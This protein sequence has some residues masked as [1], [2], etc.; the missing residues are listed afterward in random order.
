[1]GQGLI[2][3]ALRFIIKFEPYVQVNKDAGEMYVNGM[4][5]YHLIWGRAELCILNQMK[6]IK[7][8]AH[9]KAYIDVFD[10]KNSVIE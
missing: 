5:L 9:F 3:G 6:I 1:V 4:N 10:T 2:R 8:H 7:I